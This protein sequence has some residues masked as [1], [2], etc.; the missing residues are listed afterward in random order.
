VN[1]TRIQGGRNQELALA[2]ARELATPAPDLP[3]QE[4]VLTLATDGE[5]GP[6]RAAGGVVDG[7]TWETIRRTGADPAGLLAGHDSGT[8]LRL[9]PGA[10]LET[11]VTGTNVG[12]LA[13]YL[14][15]PAA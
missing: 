14:R 12:D 11:G 8:A 15:R 6:T 1:G 2:A 13:I 3:G 7:N 4:L 10:L 5:D 9:A